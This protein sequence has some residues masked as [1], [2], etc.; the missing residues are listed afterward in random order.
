VISGA[1]KD[2]KFSK[3]SKIMLAGQNIRHKQLNKAICKRELFYIEIENCLKTTLLV[4][5]S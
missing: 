1:K 3:K 5:Q 2:E 4:N